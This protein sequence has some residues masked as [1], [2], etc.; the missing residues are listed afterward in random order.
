MK[1]LA[2]GLETDL[3]AKGAT[4]QAKAIEALA[5][6]VGLMAEA[7]AEELCPLMQ[8][9]KSYGKKKKKVFLIVRDIDRKKVIEKAM[10]T[11][12]AVAKKGR[13]PAGRMER[14]LSSF[15]QRG[16]LIEDDE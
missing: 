14:V 7:D 15:L 2:T 9:K 12:G 8:I 5:D 3:Q 16:V 13:P 4:D 6:E 11:T 1:R 10:L